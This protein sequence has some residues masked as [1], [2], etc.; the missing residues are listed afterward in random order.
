M[1]T[2]VLLL[3]ESEFPDIICFDEIVEAFAIFLIEKEKL[4]VNCLNKLI[5]CAKFKKKKKMYYRR[6]ITFLYIE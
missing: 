4:S 5:S 6:K 2:L 3:V 1:K